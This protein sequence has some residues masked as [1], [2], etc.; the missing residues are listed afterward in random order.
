MTYSTETPRPLTDRR[1]W[2]RAWSRMATADDRA[3]QAADD[4]GAL[5]VD[6]GYLDPTGADAARNLD[7][8][9]AAAMIGERWAG[10]RHEFA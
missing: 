5:H 7:S 2:E 1:A 8:V 9:N 10:V 3:Q 4:R 6:A